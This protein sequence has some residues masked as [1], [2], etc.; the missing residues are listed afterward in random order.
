MKPIRK[1]LE[2]LRYVLT[3]AGVITGLITLE[4]TPVMADTGC[5]FVACWKN[6]NYICA[7]HNPS[8]QPCY[9][10]NGTYCLGPC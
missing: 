10:L 2:V 3:A 5:Y 8:C 7:N 6:V 1:R 9:N 4:D